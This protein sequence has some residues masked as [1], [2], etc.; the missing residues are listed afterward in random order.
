MACLYG[1]PAD[2]PRRLQYAKELDANCVVC[3]KP[4]K[5]LRR[6]VIRGMGKLCSEECFAALMRS[7]KRVAQPG[8]QSLRIYDYR[9]RNP[10]KW[11][12]QKKVQYAVRYGHLQKKPCE[13]CG[14]V[15]VDAHHDDYSKPLQ[16][17]WLCRKHH[18][19]E[20]RGKGMTK[21]LDAF[22][23]A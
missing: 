13:V 8:K 11:R 16:V 3:G 6:D 19:A 18:K 15:R 17:R 14:E 22:K 9:A 10:E 12:A 5:A 7:K 21:L 20:H 23:A 1:W 2:D 4:F